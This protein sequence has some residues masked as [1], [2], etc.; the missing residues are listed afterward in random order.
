MSSVQF[1]SQFEEFQF[2]LSTVTETDFITEARSVADLVFPDWDTEKEGDVG[3]FALRVYIKALVQGVNLAN[4]WAQEF[5]IFL[6]REES[7]ILAHARR[8]GFNPDSATPARVNV[9]LDLPSPL[10]ARTFDPFDLRMSTRN[11]DG[12]ANEIFFESEFAFAV[13]VATP[14][15][16]VDMVAGKSFVQN[17]TADGTDFQ[18]VILENPE[19]IDGFTRVAFLTIPWTEVEDLIDSLPT[20]L[21]FI[22]RLN[23]D[24]TTEITF[25]DGNT[26]ARPPEGEIGVI[27][28]RVGGGDLT[29]VPPDNLDF[30]ISSP[31]PEPSGTNPLKASGGKDRD[32]GEVIVK[33]ATDNVRQRDS[34]V[35]VT[36]V[37]RFAENFAGVAR[38][39]SQLAGNLIITF[40]IPEGGGAAT[41][42]LKNSLKAA[43]D[44][45][46]VMGFLSQVDDVI[47]TVPTLEVEFTTKEG[48]VSAQ[49]EA[50]VAIDLASSIN[51][52]TTVV[53][54]QTRKVSFRRSFGANLFV[55]EVRDVLN[56]R[57]E[58]EKDFSI[59]QPTADVF[60]NPTSITT[61][62]GASIT[63]RSRNERLV[64]FLTPG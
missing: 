41:T 21:H 27:D 12:V 24:G 50:A 34:L 44:D 31:L 59:L 15:V 54:P 10:L 46:L 53:D 62:V 61:D 38:A 23:P 8:L 17:V 47:F 49:V 20:D 19:V 2:K 36:E 7:S 35:T 22:T 57:P 63:A 5:N 58:V 48:F 25:G 4:A 16:I 18:T 14:Q 30:V 32:S 1:T 40:I 55:N 52:L 37:D 6:A 43:I 11:V 64:G 26:G 56:N 51:P 28:Y 9:V 45:Q 33:K 60:V 39:V 29:N 13:G 3:F 42:T